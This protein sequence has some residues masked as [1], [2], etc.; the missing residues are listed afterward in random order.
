MKRSLVL[1]VLLTVVLTLFAGCQT[2]KDPNVLY[3]EPLSEEL[4][5][6]ISYELLTEHDIKIE[7][8]FVD[9][10]YGTINDYIVLI[11]HPNFNGGVI[12]VEWQQEIADYIFKWGEPIGGFYVYRN[13]DTCELGEAYEKGWLTKEQIGKIHERHLEYYEAFPQMMT[14]WIKAQME[15]KD[16]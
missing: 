1:F 16:N 9:P 5:E 6:E 7:W 14:E 2:A 15:T 3:N 11:I 10:Y 4:K 12:T 8:G 13:G